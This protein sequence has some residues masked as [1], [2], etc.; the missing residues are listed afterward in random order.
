FQCPLCFK[1]FT[2]AENLRSHQR[3]HTH[4]RPFICGICARSF[5]RQQ[6][7][8]RHERL[9]HG[10]KQFQCGGQFKDGRSW[11]CNKRFARRE[12]LA[13]HQRSETGRRCIKLFLEQE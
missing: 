2:R 7:C 11:G 6:E 8:K 4:E 9:Q 12:G 10:E 13:I 1:E 3:T 5:V